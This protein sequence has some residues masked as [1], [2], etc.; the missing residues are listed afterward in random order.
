MPVEMGVE[1]RREGVH[2][3]V[4]RVE[5]RIEPTDQ[6]VDPCTEIEECAELCGGEDGDRGPEAASISST[7][8]APGSDVAAELVEV[9]VARAG[10]EPA[11][12]GL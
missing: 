12:S 7:S 3:S 9:L 2:P 11:T 1:A 4:E 5:A 8:V 10:F 6:R